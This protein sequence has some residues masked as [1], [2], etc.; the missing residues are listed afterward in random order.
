MVLGLD[1]PLTRN[2]SAGGLTDLTTDDQG[3]VYLRYWSPGLI[4]DASTV[5][6]AKVTDVCTSG[7][8]SLKT[9]VPKQPLT[10]QMTPQLVYRA[11]ARLPARDAYWIAGYRFFHTGATKFLTAAIEA[12]LKAGGE[13]KKVA[14]H[15]VEEEGKDVL[16]NKTKSPP[17][18]ICSPPRVKQTCSWSSCS[19]RRCQRRGSNREAHWSGVA[20]STTSPG[21]QGSS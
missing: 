1:D 7:G 15:F 10:M 16:E 21:S 8:C 6:N 4:N 11:T 18:R 5:V 9:G 19:A 17:R 13:S 20:S 2:C 3:Q 12:A 14:D